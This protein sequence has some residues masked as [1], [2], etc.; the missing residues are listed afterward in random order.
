MWNSHSHPHTVDSH[1]HSHTL[2]S[3]MQYGQYRKGHGLGGTSKVHVALDECELLVHHV[4]Q[5]LAQQPGLPEGE[6]EREIERERERER[7]SEKERELVNARD[8]ARESVCVV[9]SQCKRESDRECVCVCVCVCVRWSV[10]D[11]QNQGT[12]LVGE[13]RRHRDTTAC[14]GRG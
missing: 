13:R 9:L 10:R 12:L 5:V 4:V 6:R 14:V 3:S 8:R 7:K 1:S 2:S 11:S